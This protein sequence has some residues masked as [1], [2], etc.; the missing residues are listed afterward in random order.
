MIDYIMFKA[1]GQTLREFKKTTSYLLEEDSSNL[2]GEKTD[3]KR[4]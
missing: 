1:A 4:A 3:G 2:E